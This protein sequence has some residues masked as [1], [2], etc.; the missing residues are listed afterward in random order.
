MPSV[1]SDNMVL[2]RQS[3]VQFWGNAKPNSVVSVKASWGSSVKTMADAEGCW[4]TSLSTPEAGGPYSLT[5]SDGKAFKINDV[6]IGEVWL[7]SGQSNMEMPVKGFEGQPVNGSVDAI[8][9][10]RESL[11]LR[12]CTIAKEESLTPQKK[13]KLFWQKNIP[14]AVMNTS[15][16]AYFFGE[17]L[18][19]ILNVP[20]GIIVSAWGGTPIEMWMDKVTMQQF[21]TKE[22]LAY[23][24]SGILPD[25]ETKSPCIIY[26]SMIA[27]IEHFAIKG[28]IWY[29]GEDNR[30]V[31]EPY[32]KLLPAFAE[33]LRRN[34]DDNN[35]GFHYVQIA[36]YGYDKFP[37]TKI[38]EGALLREQQ[39][40]CESQIPNASMVPIMDIADRLC[41]HPAEKRTVGER[42]AR[43]AL[44]MEYGYKEPD[45]SAPVYGSFR[46]ENAKN[47]IVV[48]FK[49]GPDGLSPRKA[50]LQGFEIAGKDK[51]FHKAKAVVRGLDEVSVSSPDVKEPVAVRY[52]FHSWDEGTLFNS[53]GVPASSF[54]T[55]D[56][57]QAEINL[58]KHCDVHSLKDPSLTTP[59]MQW[60]DL[61]DHCLQSIPIDREHGR[62]FAMNDQRVRIKEFT[63]DKHFVRQYDK[64]Y[65]GHNNDACHIDGK[66]YIIGTK[67]A[68]DPQLWEYDIKSNTARRLDV[69][70]VLK[71]GRC[72]VLSA[73]C[74]YDD[75]S[76]LLVAQEA[77]AD[78]HGDN[79]PDDMVGIYKYD[80]KSGEVSLLFDLPWHGVFVQGATFSGGLLFIATNFLHDLQ[81]GTSIWVVDM[82]K[83]VM[84]DEMIARFEGEAEGLDYKYEDGKLYLYVGLGSPRGDYALV[85]KMLSLYQPK[86]F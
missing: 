34:W 4:K 18:Q 45:I 86:D 16:T 51:V 1:F 23:L 76:L 67:T 28:V 36:P 8:W 13:C 2:Q 55:D 74:Q 47:R 44:R 82:K 62:I 73:V 58:V 22:E 83:R 33:M 85:G 12:M 50:N 25:H 7:C 54:R 20:V 39:M 80:L 9:G 70:D 10:A 75:N 56:W 35:I 71:F 14:D 40:L 79:R 38:Y 21:R 65:T 81:G 61:N 68:N 59:L 84:I 66:L 26:N 6:L 60:I 78:I 41:I 53:F 64:P 32:G 57:E 37:R 27:P 43:E 69:M 3:Q 42:L 49:V 63:L 17:Y 31:P 72:R 5:I 19:K 77:M 48:K 46:I 29:Q 52:C 15:A 30:Y 24:E 11:P